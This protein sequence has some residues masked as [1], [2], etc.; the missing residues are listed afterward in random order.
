MCVFGLIIAIA[1]HRKAKESDVTV[2]RCSLPCWAH[3]IES[4]SML[5]R[6]IY[7]DLH[8][9]CRHVIDYTIDGH[10]YNL[11][12]PWYPGHARKKGSKIK[13][14]C[15]P[16]DPTDFIIPGERADRVLYH[17]VCTFGIFVFFLGIFMLR[18]V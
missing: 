11:T 3:I 4:S 12:T 16:E 6:D 5:E 10:Q 14:Y 15:N 8:R 2:E 1:A 13:I 9:Y 7:L 17:V 18:W